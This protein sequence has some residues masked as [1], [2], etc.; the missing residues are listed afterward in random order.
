MKFKTK[1]IIS[2]ILF[3]SLMLL[4]SFF[5]IYHTEHLKG[6]YPQFIAFIYGT[7][8]LSLS[9]G[10]FIA[11]IFQKRIELK[12]FEKF[13]SLLSNNER[14][15][16]KILFEKKEIEQNKLVVHS[17]LSNVKVSRIIKYLEFKK[18]IIKKK[19]GYTNLIILK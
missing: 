5:S 11:Y 17:G 13:L 16:I 6:I 14:K 3:F 15:I 19:S 8:L 18:I 1:I 2:G 12:E 9:L 4:L 7:S 10:A